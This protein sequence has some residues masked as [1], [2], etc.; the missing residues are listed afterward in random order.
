M[1]RIMHIKTILS[2]VA[3]FSLFACQ[4]Q[5]SERPLRQYKIHVCQAD[6]ILLPRTYSATMQGKQDI[7]IYPQVSGLITAVQVVEGEPVKQGQ[8]LFEIERVRFEADV[9]VAEANVQVAE[10]QVKTKELTYSSKQRL[11]AEKVVSA[12]DLQ[13]A[14][15]DLLTTKAQLAQ[16]QASLTNA[17][18]NLSY[19]RITAP[20]NGV[21]GR[22]PY[23]A[24]SLVSPQQEEPLTTLSDNSEMYVYFSMS[25]NQLLALMKQ[26][27]SMGNA[28]SEMPAVRLLLC[29][30]TEY[31][32]TG[33][34]ESISGLIERRTGAV[35]VRAVFPNPERQLFSGGACDIILTERR[36]EAIV[37]PQ[38]ATY[39]IQDKVFCYRV[40]DGKTVATMVS[41]R[42][43]PDGKR[44]MVLSGLE[45]GDRIIAEGAG[46][47]R[48]GEQ[49][50]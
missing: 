6:T 17:K 19:C 38:S 46:L 21:V 16:A 23:R 44:Y 42:P 14:E 15:N 34:V 40:A 5:A 20:C 50:E 29:D 41:V 32:H 18:Q 45:A 4:K 26:Y 39:E 2:A 8:T 33:H 30:G 3:V 47:I 31:C 12:Y 10:A 27:G 25:E 36:N 7:A 22:L 43:L 9:R 24:G 48:E 35:S 13:V 49:V 11:Y 28:L 37:I 1:N